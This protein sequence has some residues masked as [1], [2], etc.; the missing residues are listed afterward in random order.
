MTHLIINLTKFI[1]LLLLFGDLIKI[2]KISLW[3]LSTLNLLLFIDLIFTD[4][5]P[6]LCSFKWQYY[7][8]PVFFPCA[9]IFLCTF[10]RSAKR[11]IAQKSIYKT[12]LYFWIPLFLN[13]LKWQ[14]YHFP[15]MA[16]CFVVLIYLQFG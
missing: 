12:V 5:L 2:L 3:F 14:P 1:I 13:F 4:S 8:S 6:I 11:V 16:L 9:C 7:Q 15:A 10:H